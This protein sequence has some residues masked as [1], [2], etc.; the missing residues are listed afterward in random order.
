MRSKWTMIPA[1]ILLL[2]V[3]AGCQAHEETPAERIRSDIE[4]L[5]SDE[6]NGRL[7]GSQGNELAMDYIQE[8]FER[9]GLSPLEG[10]DSLLVPYEQSVFEMDSEQI[11]TATFSDGSVKTFRAGKDFY[12]C[13]V[14][15]MNGG[16]FSGEVT[17]NPLDPDLP[18]KVYLAQHGEPI[19]DALAVV[20]ESDRASSILIT[21]SPTTLFTCNRSVFQQL[22]ECKSLSLEGIAAVKNKM[23]NNVVGVLPSRE[24]KAE[25]A[26]LITAHFD[27][28]GG[29]SDTIYRGGM[30]NASGV[31]LLLEVM[32][33]LTAAGN[34]AEYDI[35][36]AAFNGEDMELLGSKALAK[37]LPYKTVNVINF[38]CVGYKEEPTLGVVGKNKELQTAVISAFSDSLSC[39]PYDDAPNSDH[40]SFEEHG[41]PAVTV[42]N[43]FGE[44]DVGNI[45]HQ[46]TDTP[47][48]LDFDAISTMV[49]PVCKYSLEGRLIQT[50]IQDTKSNGGPTMEE[51]GEYKD[52]LERVRSEITQIGLSYDQVLPMERL[53]IGD[54]QLVVFVRDISFMANVAA[55][56]AVISPAKF[57]ENLGSFQL[58]REAPLVGDSDGYFLH[59]RLADSGEDYEIGVPQKIT[60]AR[61]KIQ[62]WS[63]K[64]TDG[65]VFLTLAAMDQ[66]RTDMESIL[67]SEEY[68]ELQVGEGTIYQTFLNFESKKILRAVYYVADKLPYCYVLYNSNDNLAAIDNETLLQMMID[69]IPQLQEIPQIP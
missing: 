25:N 37:E 57:P 51:V 12:P 3:L 60:D 38:D 49:E 41:V 34:T 1:A 4:F 68:S 53:R 64:Y 13:L 42:S 59:I 31:S 63:L 6:C 46:P 58:D 30:D 29:Y 20:V 8:T 62:N 45:I 40:N 28:V 16:G 5:C 21:G 61:D 36:F 56:E 44:I 24:G 69:V 23:M 33:Q 43:Y 18:N 55:A 10:Y 14:L 67:L 26:L 27:H 11:L 35:V 39:V 22:T 19:V 66:Q 52:F 50:E 17:T 2:V 47:D 15:D 32:R 65:N 54:V 7:P 9:E 48:I